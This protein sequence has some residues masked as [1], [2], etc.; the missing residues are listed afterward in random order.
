MDPNATLKEI[1]NLQAEVT[2]RRL[3]GGSTYHI[4]DLLSAIAERCEAL[5][6]WL[7]KGGF[8]PDAWTPKDSS[9]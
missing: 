9:Q 8:L 6:G 2:R 7:S 1:R 4:A 5:D 3:A